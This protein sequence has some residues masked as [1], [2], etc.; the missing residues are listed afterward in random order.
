MVTDRQKDA[1]YLVGPGDLLRA[2]YQR[3]FTKQEIGKCKLK[4]PEFDEWY[5]TLNPAQ[6][7]RVDDQLEKEYNP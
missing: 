2:A 5:A 7:K 3:D 4:F 1:S 6:R